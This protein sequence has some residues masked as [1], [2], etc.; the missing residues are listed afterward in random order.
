MPTNKGQFKLVLDA[1]SEAVLDTL[2]RR[3]GISRAAVMRQ[4]LRRFAQ[5]EGVEIPDDSE[6]GKAAA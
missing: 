1:A 4:A 2:A 3:L 6:L 5:A